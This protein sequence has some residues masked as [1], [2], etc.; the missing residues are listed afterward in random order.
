MKFS[1]L[2]IG[3]ELTL[4]LITNTN[5]QII[6]QYLTD[7][8]IEC[9]YIITVK[10]NES[11][12]IDALDICSKFS[13]IIVVCG[14]LG[15]TD[16]DL[17]RSAFAKFLG[18]KLIK[19]NDLDK[20]SLR[21]L[22]YINNENLIETLTRQSYIP[23]N[24][25]AIKPRVGSASG[26]IVEKNDKIFFSIPGV[27]REMK[28]MLIHD[29][30]PYIKNFLNRKKIQINNEIIQK[31]ILY[32]TDISE[33]QLEYSIKDVKKL[34]AELNIDIGVTASPG[35]I[36]I[37]LI[38]K[39]KNKNLGRKNLEEIKRQI[40]NLIGDNIYQ[41]GEGTIG[42][43]IKSVINNC[44]KNIT[45]SAAESITGG[46]I[47]S[48]ITDTPGSS[49]YFLGSIISY[50]NYAKNKLLRVDNNLL[51][52]EGAVSIDVCIEMAKNCQKIFS[53][54]FAISVTGYAGSSQNSLVQYNAK[55]DVG[56]V[57]SCVITPNG[58][59]ETYER[60]FIGTRTDIKFF[61]SL[62]MIS[63]FKLIKYLC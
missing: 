17:T 29:L 63:L 23:Q 21:F 25:V 6:A 58:L 40:F 33:S 47:S 62:K 48:L 35:L 28:D 14:G 2:S 10:D 31:L 12:I 18:E 5:A 54:D 56:L 46:L 49:N 27:P 20:T 43:S 26:F 19:I 30:I 51:N 55:E 59:I 50:S 4:G 9:S 42:D 61:H 13:D 60:K 8:G 24:A 3:T 7:L 36:K 22:K 16:D 45:I 39:T 38:A 41:I 57:F 11:E 15:P 44:K 1:V 34:A 37:M 53:S 32:T 52:K